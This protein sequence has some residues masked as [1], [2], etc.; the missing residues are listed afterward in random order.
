MAAAKKTAKSSRSTS[1]PNPLFT[2]GFVKS[3]GR[4]FYFVYNEKTGSRKYF[5]NLKSAKEYL[6]SKLK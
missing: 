5:E 4:P 3:F 6:N 2:I 1:F